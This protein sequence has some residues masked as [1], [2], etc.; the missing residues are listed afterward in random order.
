LFWLVRERFGRGTPASAALEAARA[1]PDD[2]GAVREVAVALE[3]LAR[4][5]TAFDVRV[6]E[7]WGQ[8][9]A[10]LSASEGVINSATGS[11]GGHLMHAA[12]RGTCGGARP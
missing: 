10:E 2:E 12:G 6:R 1:D 4:E 8:A 11:V 5:D 3:R 9:S 7:L